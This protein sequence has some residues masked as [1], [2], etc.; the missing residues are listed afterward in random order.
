MK[1]FLKIPAYSDLCGVVRNRGKFPQIS[2]IFALR[3]VVGSRGRNAAAELAKSLPC[4][5]RASE[6]SMRYFRRNATNQPP[7]AG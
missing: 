6:N 7:I 4:P 5:S 3:G 1:K 2:V